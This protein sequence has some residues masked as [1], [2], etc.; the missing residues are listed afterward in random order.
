MEGTIC[1]EGITALE[2]PFCD[3][4]SDAGSVIDPELLLPALTVSVTDSY[5]K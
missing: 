2:E 3:N 4:E 5:N 1:L